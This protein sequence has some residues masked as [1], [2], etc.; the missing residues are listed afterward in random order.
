MDK[1]AEVEKEYEKLKSFLQEPNE[2]P[3][4]DI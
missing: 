2:L 1:K 4:E 3:Q